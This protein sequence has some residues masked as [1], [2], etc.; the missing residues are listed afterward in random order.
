[1]KSSVTAR[2]RH[3][4]KY[5]GLDCTMVCLEKHCKESFFFNN[6]PRPLLMV[7]LSFFPPRVWG[8]MLEV[9]TIVKMLGS[10]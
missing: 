8:K 6:G 2:K 1:M 10:V 9:H 4:I 7:D 3:F 5:S